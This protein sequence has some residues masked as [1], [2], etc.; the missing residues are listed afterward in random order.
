M[1]RGEKGRD[2]FLGRGRGWGGWFSTYA[3]ESIRRPKETRRRERKDM[4]LDL[5]SGRERTADV[6]G[7][8][9]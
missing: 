2:G 1:W 4:V 7:A 9:S 3:W 8:G 6:W 5:F